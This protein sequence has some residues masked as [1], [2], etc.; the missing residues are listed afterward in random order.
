MISRHEA[1]GKYQANPN[2]GT[3]AEVALA[4]RESQYL[5]PQFVAYSRSMLEHMP[6]TFEALKRGEINE[7]RAMIIVRETSEL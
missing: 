5:G 6:H 1:E 2:R 4:R 7:E 3:G